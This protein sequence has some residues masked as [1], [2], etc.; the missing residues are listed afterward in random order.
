MWIMQL[1][2]LTEGIAI[3]LSVDANSIVITPQK[4]KKYTLDDLLSWYNS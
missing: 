1:Y 3:N 4:R 2:N